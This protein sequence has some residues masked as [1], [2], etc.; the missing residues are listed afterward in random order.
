MSYPTRRRFL[1]AA[2]A[3]SLGDF[4]ALWPLGPATAD[5]ARVIPGLVQFGPDMEPIV[6]LI[7]TTPEERC[8]AVM[9]EQLRNGLPYRHFL[10][11]LYLAAIRAAKWHGQVHAYDH[12]AYIVHSAYQ[13]ALD[14]PA[15]EQLLP[16]F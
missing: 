10:A 7:E 3:A 12:N 16:A 14:L 1:A 4:A 9:V 8:V 2:G 13:L 11:A 5:E 6:R 15:G